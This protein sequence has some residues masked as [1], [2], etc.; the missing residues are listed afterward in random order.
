MGYLVHKGA[1]PMK[2]NILPLALGVFATAC[3]AGP[4]RTSPL[5]I[6][7]EYPF[8]EVPEATWE[9]L[10]DA[11]PL[12]HY[13][14][15]SDGSAVPFGISS[16]NTID[17]DQW[18]AEIATLSAPTN[19]S[20]LRIWDGMTAE[21]Y[22]TPDHY[23]TTKNAR[24]ELTKILKDN[25]SIH[26][27]SWTWCNEDDYWPISPSKE[28]NTSLTDYFRIMDSLEQE[29]SNVT[30]IY[31]TAAIRDPDGAGDAAILNQDRFNDSLRHW[32]VK[33]NK[34]LF[35][36]ADLDAWHAGEHHTLVID[37]DTVD[38]QHPFWLQ[39]NGPT[40]GGHHANDS[41]GVDK[42][43]AWWTLMAM[44][45]T[46]WKPSTTKVINRFHGQEPVRL[47]QASQFDL[48]GRKSR[49]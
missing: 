7:H 18:P 14:H 33:N 3:L 49:K 19:T 37:G 38:F 32:A 8:S 44:L 15:R 11:N 47:F 31:Q 2:Q 9:T 24:D 13:A 30:F 26:Y 12:I 10:R 45:E 46:G 20:G 21:T 5:I 41:M 35:D 1:P 23:W 42:G 4:A 48:L 36:V 22:V 40:N 25:P 39:G 17:A 27:T 43:K 34:V 6:D 16:L 29:F 28:D